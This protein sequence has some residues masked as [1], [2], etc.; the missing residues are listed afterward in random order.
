MDSLLTALITL[1]CLCDGTI[2]G[3]LIRSRL[4]DHHIRDDS[5]DVIKIASG[6]IATL[7][8]LVI[9]L[10][11]SSSKSSY[12]QAGSGLTQNG[13]KIILLDHALR[14]YGPETTAI[15]ERLRKGIET[16]IEGLWPSDRGLKPSLAVAERGTHLDDVQDMIL[17]LA[18][19]DGTRRDIRSHALQTCGELM[20]S[21][22][23]M[24]E[25]T[26]TTLPTVFLAILI[27]WLTVLFASFGLLAP[28]NATAWSS[29]FVCAVSMAGAIYLILEMNRPFEGALRISP[30]PLLKAVSVIG[31]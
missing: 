21:R 3:S 15:R 22:W 25:Q 17:Q 6:M 11:V 16:S 31:K 13:A 8:A 26:Q 5:K 28:R 24:I 4:P 10:L 7:V 12:D 2:V 1:A 23:L 29:L 20:Q 18:P 9:G 14:R 30:A 27:F 19:Q